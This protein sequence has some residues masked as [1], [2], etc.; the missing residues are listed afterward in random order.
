[1]LTYFSLKLLETYQPPY[2]NS[3]IELG[4]QIL[5]IGEQYVG[6]PAKKYFEERG[7]SHTSID[8][9]GKDGALALDLT[10]DLD[11]APAQTVT[12]WGTAE[13][14]SDLYMCYKNV[15]A[16]CM[17]AGI[18]FHENPMAG[19]FPGHGYHFFTQDFFHALAKHAGYVLLQVGE[20]AAYG[21]TLDGW[22]VHAVLR[23]KLD[24]EF[25]S[26]EVWDKHVFPH[27]KQK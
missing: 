16:M 4:N 13:H 22:N 19:N 21:N 5:D 27:I 3:M 18:M 20:N 25:I 12:D 23:K 6:V 2:F 1:M 15:H 11:V 14:V 10:T 24:G 17:P 26:R 8:T 7:F 9:N